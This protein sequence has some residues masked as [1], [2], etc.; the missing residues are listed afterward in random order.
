MLP[1]AFVPLAVLTACD[2]PMD[3]DEYDLPVAEIVDVRVEPNPV[4]DTATFTC[5][6]ERSAPSLRFRWS[7]PGG[8]T[9]TDTNQYLWAES[10]PPGDYRTIVHVDRPEEPFEKVIGSA[11]FTVVA[12]E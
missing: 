12:K 1:F 5:V 4:G 9:I 3:G 8:A 10:V 6:V 2:I 11:R 7:F